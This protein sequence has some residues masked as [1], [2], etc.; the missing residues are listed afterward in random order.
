MSILKLP[1]ELLQLVIDIAVQ[2]TELQHASKF[3]ETC[4]VLPQDSCRTNNLTRSR[5]IRLNRPEFNLSPAEGDA[6]SKKARRG[7]DTKTCSLKDAA[8][9]HR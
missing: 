6:P 4:R 2:Q 7:Y 3:R 8:W 9:K 5:T 1:A